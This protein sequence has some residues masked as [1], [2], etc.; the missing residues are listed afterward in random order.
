MVHHNHKHG[1]SGSKGRPT[2]LFTAW[3]NMRDR[4]D[5]PNHKAYH[6]YGGRG[7]KVCP[8][9]YDFQTFARDVGPAQRGMQIE[10]NNN[11]GDYEPGNV[12]WAT[13][14]EQAHNRRTNK[15]DQYT[16]D[17][18][19]AVYSQGKLPQWRV[20]QMFGVCQMTVSLIIQ[21]K[22]W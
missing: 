1:Q 12:R 7:V 16:A 4:C 18:I 11:N 17:Q 5:N 6:N 9:W 22:I 19:R 10:R 3:V 21:G 14:K 8:Q 2:Q 20:G 15:L 13:V